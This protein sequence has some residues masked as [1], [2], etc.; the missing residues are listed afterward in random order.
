MDKTSKECEGR[1]PVPRP[2]TPA[3]APAIA[4]IYNYYIANT[5]ITFEEEMLDPGRMAERIQAVIPRYPWFV[6][7]EEGELAGYAYAHAWHQRAAY[8]FAAEDSIYLKRGWERRGIGGRLLERVIGEL[9]EQ[10]CHVLMAVITVPNENSVGLHENLGFKK[11]G[12]FNEIG[13]KLG[14]RLDVG[15]W[16]LILGEGGPR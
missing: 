5:A 9:R 1:S 8:R 10:G 11:V 4:E 3:D 7:E 13:F 15:Y 16:E 12:Q 2:V 14:K 6:W